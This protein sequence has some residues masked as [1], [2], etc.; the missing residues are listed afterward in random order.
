MLSKFKQLGLLLAL[1]I[2]VMVPAGAQDF[3]PAAFTAT[4]EQIQSA[5]RFVEAE[6]VITDPG[7]FEVDFESI[8]RFLAIRRL[9]PEGVSI[10]DYEWG[11]Y[12]GGSPRQTQPVTNTYIALVACHI[13]TEACES[14]ATIVGSRV[15]SHY[16]TVS[17]L[18][19]LA[20]N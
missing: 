3:E 14:F 19:D 8:A 1:V 18:Q 11:A 10:D 15:R 17:V 12:V 6:D 20:R 16:A 13:R 9:N 5:D 7:L 4:L 2:A